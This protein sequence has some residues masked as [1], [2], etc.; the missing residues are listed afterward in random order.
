MSAEIESMFS[1][2]EKPWHYE[3]T[4][5]RTSI[6]QQAP[7]S[8]DAIRA[9]GLDWLVEGKPV[10]DINGKEIKGYKANTRDKDGEVLGI[11]SNK[12]KVVQN[13]EAFDFT[14]SLVGRGLKYETAGSLRN[15]KTIWMLGKIPETSIL[16]DEIAPY[17]VFT[18]SHDGTGAIRVAV[19]PIRV[20]CNNTLNLALRTAKRSWSVSHMG[21]I[22][23][24]LEEAR[25]TLEL[26]DA[27]MEK[28]DEE[29]VKLANETMTDDEI[30]DA[31][32]LMF[33]VA[34]D[35]SD[36]TKKTVQ[37]TK[38]QILMC[39]LAP[40]LVKFLN[41]KWGFINAVSDYVGHGEP[42]RRTANYDENRWGNIIGGR[43]LIDRAM[44]VIGTM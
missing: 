22:Q 8:S 39:T 31:L 40:D 29:A 37:N 34:D 12:Y 1:V 20:V 14:D 16:G 35:A 30:H 27:Y 5:G 15:G 32:D 36:R 41:T 9:A 25:R 10:F 4:K 42:A 23:A 44:S 28:L 26:A 17:I 43:T 11:V 13:W 33:P 7:V 19:T 24:K 18:N 6:I 21:N 2:R 38:D 3:M